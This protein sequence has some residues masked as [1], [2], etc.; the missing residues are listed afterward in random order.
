MK[1]GFILLIVFSGL[2]A[3]IGYYRQKAASETLKA[4]NYR[5][6]NDLLLKQIR[7]VYEEKIKL[8]HENEILENM[9]KEESAEFDWY[10]DISNSAVIKRLQG[11]GGRIS[12]N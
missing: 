2:V 5:Q 4:E 3:G 9:A 7:R 11:K 8:Q 10:R 12:R 6:N 1:Q